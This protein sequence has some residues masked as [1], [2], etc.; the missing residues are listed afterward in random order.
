MKYYKKSLGQNFLIDKNIIRKI[1]SI[2]K[3]RNQNIIEIGPGKGAITCEILKLKPKTLSVI[4]KDPSLAKELK[5]KFLKKKNVFIYNQDILNFN[6]EKICKKNSIV[7]GNLPYNISSQILIKILN[8][9]NWPPNI[10]DVIFMFQKELG[11]KILGNFS[12]N[13]YGRLS[14][15]SNYRLNPI[16]KFL[17]SPNCFFPKPKV[18]SLVIHFQPKDKNQNIKD[19]NNLEKITNLLFSSKRKIIKKKIEKILSYSEIKKIRDLKL[20]QRPSE[21]KPE[22]YYKITELFE[23]D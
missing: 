15:I 18:N 16:S 4:E 14:I 21:I 10:K 20:N 19:I 8:F 1:T 9:K 6:I 12:S 7:F 17:V 22:A 11:E 2:V 13:N 3:V 5:K 23:K